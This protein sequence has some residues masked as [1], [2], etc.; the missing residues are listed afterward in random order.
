MPTKPPSPASGLVRGHAFRLLPNSDLVSSLKDASQKA[1]INSNA[2]SCFVM[3]AVG[4]L[5]DVTLRLA[6]APKKRKKQNTNN[7]QDNDELNGAND[8][9]TATSSNDI[10]H[11]KDE[12]FEVVSLVGT[13]SMSSGFHLHMSISNATGETFGGHVMAGTIYTTMEIV[14]GTI[15]TVK[16]DR[17]VDDETGY[18][19]L[20]VTQEHE[21]PKDETNT[22]G[23]EKE[24]T[25]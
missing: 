4:S 22:M 11:W 10:R 9:T 17:L 23:G 20:V 21:S 12:K 19:E 13:F 24:K 15:D 5:S 8:N 14:L 6:S 16:F 25:F 1:M 3:T 2:S 7:N 18:R